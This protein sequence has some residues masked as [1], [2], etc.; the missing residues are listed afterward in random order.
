[1]EVHRLGVQCCSQ[2]TWGI[3]E[4]P[5]PGV[6]APQVV[7]HRDPKGTQHDVSCCRCSWLSACNY[8]VGHHCWGHQTFWWQDIEKSTWSWLRKLAPSW[9]NFIVMEGAT[10]AGVG[11]ESALRKCWV[12]RVILTCQAWCAHC[13]SASSGCCRV[14]NHFPTELEAYSTG[15]NLYLDT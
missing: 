2:K 6:A 4:I 10:Q 15:G 9:L 12:L 13:C 5:V 1:M 14:N 7:G 8:M 11:R 3:N